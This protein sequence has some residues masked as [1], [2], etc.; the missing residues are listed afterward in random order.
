MIATQLSEVFFLTKLDFPGE[1]PAAA[2]GLHRFDSEEFCG[3]TVLR[4]WGEKPKIEDAVRHLTEESP[5]RWS[6]FKD[7]AVWL[8]HAP[9]GESFSDIYELILLRG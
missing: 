3:V 2:L 7:T 6:V 5:H 9:A 8:G 4:L 1:S